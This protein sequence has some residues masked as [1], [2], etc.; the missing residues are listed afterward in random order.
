M[1]NLTHGMQ[2]P[3]NVE[4]MPLLEHQWSVL[5][6][7]QGGVWSAASVAFQCS[8][9]RGGA[10]MSANCNM[11]PR[12]IDR[13]S[14]RLSSFCFFLKNISAY[15]ILMHCQAKIPSLRQGL[16]YHHHPQH[17]LPQPQL[18]NEVIE[19]QCW[20][21]PSFTLLLQYNQQVGAKTTTKWKLNN[22]ETGNELIQIHKWISCT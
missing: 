15:C 8:L 12:C 13:C 6:S 17:L 14:G 9:A 18:S 1:S 16:Q 7:L 21:N 2:K 10:G 5:G 3:W 20:P 22:K 4:I 19:L 11:A